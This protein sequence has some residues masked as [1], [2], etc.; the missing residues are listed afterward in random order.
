MSGGFDTLFFLNKNNSK[1]K[2]T[3]TGKD[4]EEQ[5][6]ALE[7]DKMLC[8]W[9]YLGDS[10]KLLSEDRQA[11]L[12]EI[13]T[14]YCKPQMM[15]NALD[16]PIKKVYKLLQDLKAKGYVQHDKFGEY[17]IVAPHSAGFEGNSS[18]PASSVPHKFSIKAIL[19]KTFN[20]LVELSVGI[21]WERLRMFCAE[22]EVD[23]EAVF[24]Q[25]LDD[26]WIDQHGA[27]VRLKI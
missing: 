9:Q 10:E 24:Q 14:G 22:V 11:I 20:N 23:A 13:R 18:T 21:F 4:I 17:S 1:V 15:A 12:E 16:I 3:T 19:V 5:E 6:Y 7:F 27:M 2:L 26:G 8:A 25:A